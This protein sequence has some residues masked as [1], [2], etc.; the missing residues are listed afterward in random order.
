V[1]TGKHDPKY[2]GKVRQQL[3]ELSSALDGN[4][5]EPFSEIV[6]AASESKAAQ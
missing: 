6:K 1:S 4:V 2:A 3:Y 5:K